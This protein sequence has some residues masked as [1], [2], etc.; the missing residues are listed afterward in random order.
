MSKKINLIHHG[1]K[2]TDEMVQEVHEL[3]NELGMG[4]TLAAQVVAND[5]GLIKKAVSNWMTERDKG[6]H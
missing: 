4:Y 2:F 3:V 5:H 6:Y 1:N